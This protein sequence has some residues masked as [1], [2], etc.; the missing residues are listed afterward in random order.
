[1]SSSVHL[2]TGDKQSKVAKLSLHDELPCTKTTIITAKPILAR[3]APRINP[4]KQGLQSIPPVRVRDPCLAPVSTVFSP[5]TDSCS[6][7]LIS[8]IRSCR[9]D[10]FWKGDPLE[11]YCSR[12]GNVGNSIQEKKRNIVVELFLMKNNRPHTI[13]CATVDECM[14]ALCMEHFNGFIALS[15]LIRKVTVKELYAISL[16]V[17]T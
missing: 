17:S 6:T 11:K 3:R 13:E 9:Y 12:T 1:M 8:D 14:L 10:R 2:N 5:H 16:R 4:I 15:V 7:L